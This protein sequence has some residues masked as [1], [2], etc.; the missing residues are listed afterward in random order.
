MMCVFAC[1]DIE[2]QLLFI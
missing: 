2:Q 1:V